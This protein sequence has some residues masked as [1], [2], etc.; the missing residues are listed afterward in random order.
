MNFITTPFGE[1]LYKV[2]ISALRA[3][4]WFIASIK[5]LA[6]RAQLCPYGKP[7][8]GKLAAKAR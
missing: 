3:W 2:Y 6:G 4:G 1:G 5:H 7:T 8:L